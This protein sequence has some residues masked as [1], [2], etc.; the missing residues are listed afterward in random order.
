VSPFG[1]N[2][3]G[4]IAGVAYVLG[5][6]L[7]EWMRVDDPVGTVAVD[8]VWAIWSTLSQRGGSRHGFP[9]WRGDHKTVVWSKAPSTFTRSGWP[10]AGRGLLRFEWP[11][12][13]VSADGNGVGCGGM[14]VPW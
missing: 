10:S 3:L 6:E 4:G 7:E 11:S 8:G 13:A 2:L 12:T 1:A 9:P 14:A 5:I